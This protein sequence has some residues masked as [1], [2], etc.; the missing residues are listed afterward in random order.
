MISKGRVEMF[1]HLCLLFVGLVLS[2][3][4]LRLGLG[5]PTEPGPGFL[6]FGTGV[7]LFS[8]SIVGLLKSRKGRQTQK[9]GAF[10]VTVKRGIMGVALALVGYAFA[11]PRLG[12]L[13][14]TFL[15]MVFLFSLVEHRKWVGILLKATIVTMATYLIFE[16]WLSC[17][18]PQGVLWF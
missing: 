16:K 15:L 14:S 6:P 18:L 3:A 11:L 10:G 13:L 1:G 7:L 17:Q 9:G 8:T 12:Y 5:V 2:V 4:S